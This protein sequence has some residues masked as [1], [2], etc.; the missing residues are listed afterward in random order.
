MEPKNVEAKPEKPVIGAKLE[1]RKKQGT[2]TLVT[3]PSFFQNQNR[4]FCL[5]NL[6]KKDKD[7]FAN[8]VNK[9]FPKEDLTIYLWDDNN[10]S[11]L[12][13]FGNDSDPEYEKYLE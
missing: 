9:W 6:S 11:Q 10:F 12:D 7:N 8:A 1:A 5:I 13:P 3:P 2:I 4:S